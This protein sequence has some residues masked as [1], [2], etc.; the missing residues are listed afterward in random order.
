MGFQ[1]RRFRQGF[2]FLLGLGTAIGLGLSHP[3]SASAFSLGD[4]LF[5]GVQIIQLSNLSEQQQGAIKS[6][7]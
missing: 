5:H 3:V 6:G 2:S 7:S 1:S 4:L